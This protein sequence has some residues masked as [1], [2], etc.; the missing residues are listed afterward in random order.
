MVESSGDFLPRVTHQKVFA[1]EY[2]VLRLGKRQKGSLAGLE[3]RAGLLPSL[4]S[5]VCLTVRQQQP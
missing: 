5:L 1:L 2:C 4:F 3:P